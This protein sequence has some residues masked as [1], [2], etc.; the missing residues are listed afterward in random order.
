MAKIFRA[1]PEL[2]DGCRICEMVCSLTKTKQVNPYSGRIR[3]QREKDTGSRPLYCRHCTR[4]LC[5]EACPVPQAMTRDSVTGAV[6]IH[7]QHCIGCL[8]CAEACP[9]DAIWVGPDREMLKCDLCGGDPVC[10]RYCPAKPTPDPDT[11]TNSYFH[12]LQYVEPRRVNR[13]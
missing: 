1:D 8:E 13:G 10:V 5:R 7:Q 11:S 6:A 3:V 4:P 2:C 12:C 9:F